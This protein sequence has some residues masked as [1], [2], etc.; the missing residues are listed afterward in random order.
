[1]DLAIAGEP[2]AALTMLGDMLNIKLK[3]REAA[4]DRR[5]KLNGEKRQALLDSRRA[6]IEAASTEADQLCLGRPLRERGQ[7][8]Q[9]HDRRG[10]WRAL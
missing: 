4:T 2:A 8:R 3:G 6:A 7:G 1:M 10:D 9:H 5:R